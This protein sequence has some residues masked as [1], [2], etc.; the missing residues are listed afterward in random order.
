MR[1]Y[2]HCAASVPY[3]EQIRAAMPGFDRQS[4]RAL[5]L[6]RSGD[7]VCLSSPVDIDHLQFL[8]SIGLGPR[9]EDVIVA[10]GGTE[11]GRLTP[12]CRRILDSPETFE[13]LVQRAVTSPRVVVH[14]FIASPSHVMLA[15]ALE[16]AT[17][18][19]TAVASGAQRLVDEADRKDR[20]RD[21]ARELGLPVAEGEIVR[22]TY[23]G[24]R[25]RRDVVHLRDAI[26]RLSSR[27]GRVIVRG[28]WGASGTSSFIVSRG[29]YDVDT[30]VQEIVRRADNDA[31][32]VEVMVDAVA[33]PNIQLE[34]SQ[35]DGAIYYLGATEQRWS[36]P[37]VH[38]GNVYPCVADT[39][40]EMVRWSYVLAEWLRGEGYVGIFGADFVEYVDPSTGER[41]I[42]F[43]E[44]NPRVNGSTFPLMLARTLDAAQ[45]VARRPACPAFVSGTVTTDASSF[46]ALY[47]RAGHLFYRPATGA[48]AVPYLVGSPL[49]GKYSAAVLAGTR[50]AAVE[51]MAELQR[52]SQSE[53]IAS[54]VLA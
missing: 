37:L 14:P 50:D 35:D 33:S 11:H 23:P 47:A 40:P 26:A 18:I 16:I 9:L 5:V 17:K 51:M 46:A 1:I 4:E 19:P 34:I 53:P 7:I 39:L 21:T 38:A 24:G 28:A 54:A 2:A 29:G 27:T 15:R 48:G 12:L 41:R 52:A 20:M 36:R 13:W 22:L 25:R 10:P 3:I 49:D 31:Y 32:L 44:V 45:R 8:G 42:L 30:L 6:A 43:A